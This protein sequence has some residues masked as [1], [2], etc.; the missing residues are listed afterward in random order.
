MD[1]RTDSRARFSNISL[2]RSP[3]FVRGS[4][5]CVSYRRNITS[6]LLTVVRA[7]YLSNKFSKKKK[8]KID[9]L[10]LHDDRL[11]MR[12]ISK[13]TVLSLS[14]SSKRW[15]RKIGILRRIYESCDEAR[16]EDVCREIFHG[17]VF[18][19]ISRGRVEDNDFNIRLINYSRLGRVKRSEHSCVRPINY[20]WN[21][22]GWLARR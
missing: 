4:H 10:P 6:L 14:F 22:P 1:R 17:R 20:A 2:I 9:S 5:Y 12:R 16:M 15:N 21:P 3:W 8:E 11:T 13:K 18:V 19:R 7:N